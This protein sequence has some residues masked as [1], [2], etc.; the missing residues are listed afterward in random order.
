MNKGTL[1][2]LIAISALASSCSDE[3]A[4]SDVDNEEAKIAAMFNGFYSGS[5]YSSVTNTTE[6][7]TM[8]FSPYASAQKIELPYSPGWAWV[9]GTV[10]YSKYYNDHL[11]EVS[12]QCYYTVT[13]DY[14]GATTVLRLYPYGDNGS[15][16]SHNYDYIVSSVTPTSFVMRLEGLTADNNK[17]M[18]RK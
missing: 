5:T 1:L 13:M 2:T 3:P 12:R 18:N 15:V 17:T 6:T 9:F 7:E 11:L 4:T 8:N 14:V 16:N 10:D